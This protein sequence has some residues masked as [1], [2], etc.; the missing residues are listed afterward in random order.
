MAQSPTFPPGNLMIHT[1]CGSKY[2]GIAVA[3]AEMEV[4]G[5]GGGGDCMVL[6]PLQ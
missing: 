5:R 1:H 6:M 3:A 4:P 2:C